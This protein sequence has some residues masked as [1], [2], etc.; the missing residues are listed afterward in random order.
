MAWHLKDIVETR[1]AVDIE[2]TGTGHQRSTDCLP[3]QLKSADLAISEA[4]HPLET[5][6]AKHRKDTQQRFFLLETSAVRREQSNL[7][8]K[9]R[10]RH[11]FLLFHQGCPK[12]RGWQ[13][14]PHNP[15]RTT[16]GRVYAS[17]SPGFVAPWAKRSAASSWTRAQWWW[18]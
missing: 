15:V 12:L 7:G 13:S 14:P 17:A 18:A 5:P 11:W 10:A 1:L 8:C 3:A 2:L 16:D 6:L 9:G 4:P